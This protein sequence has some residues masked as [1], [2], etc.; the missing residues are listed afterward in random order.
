M[1]PLRGQPV[2]RHW[3]S[4]R[5]VLIA[6]RLLSPTVCKQQLKIR[7]NGTR[8]QNAITLAAVTARVVPSVFCMYA[9]AHA[10]RSGRP[11]AAS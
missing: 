10:I 1:M 11:A 3:R 5:H 6:T 9:Y 2:D 7:I 4:D 8:V